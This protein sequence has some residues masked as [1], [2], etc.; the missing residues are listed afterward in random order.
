MTDGANLQRT[1]APQ[2]EQLEIINPDAP[3]PIVQYWNILLRRKWPALAVIGAA[4]VVGLVATLLMAPIYT[5][6]GRIEISRAQKKITNVEGVESEDAGRDIEF[7]QT[8]YNLLKARSLAERV[9]RQLKLSSDAAFFEAHGLDIK[10]G[11]STTTGLPPTSAERAARERE[12]VDMLLKHVN[13]APLRGSSLVDVGYDSG[14]PTQ[15]ARIANAWIKQFI[16]ASIDRRFAST[17]DARAFLERQLSNLREKLEQSER[18]AVNYAS[19]RQIATISR[20]Q[21]PD[22]R[23]QSEKT[24]AAADLETMSAELQRAT[25]DRIA[26]QSRANNMGKGTATAETLSNPAINALRQKRAEVAADYAKILVQFEPEYPAARALK[27]QIDTM[28]ASIS[29]EERRVT[30]N[31]NQ[32]LQAAVQREAE[33]K[34]KVEDLV[35]RLDQQQKSSIQ[36]N[37]YQR[38]ADTNRQLYDSLLQ[39]YKEIGVAGVD[40][41]NISIVDSARVPDRPSAPSLMRNLFLAFLAGLILAALLIVIL[42]QFDEGLRDPED[43]VRK[44]NQPLLGVSP[45]KDT[46]DITA[47]LS[48]PKSDFTEAYISIISNL[49]FSTDHGV[50]RSL[51]IT[52]TR[53]AEGKSS[54]SLALAAVLGRTEK[55]VIL[56]DGD[57]RSPSVHTIVGDSNIS[58][59]SNYLAGDDNWKANVR[60]TSMKGVSIL[61]A[62]PMPPNAAELLSRPRIKD[63]ITELS[64]EYDHIIVDSPPVLGLA[65]GLLIAK[66]V[67]GTVFV[68]EAKG[69]P[70]RGIKASIARLTGVGANIL[71]I[72]LTKVSLGQVGYGYGYG[73]GYGRADELE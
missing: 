48:D 47:D 62:G 58:G 2:G 7:Y 31:R 41:N 46:T 4:L 66:A 16:E 57:M 52:S 65:D 68:S 73:Y 13:V 14:S 22:G 69:A 34:A 54:S 55:R 44:L 12:T 19:T 27:R 3:P 25:T 29:N 71:G 39:R 9:A 33:L 35:A 18:D 17:S 64:H 45:F 67:E 26:A 15:S 21:G 8:Q 42:E 5:A 50:P 36:Y 6:T 24:L 60:A 51:A 70:V 61:T 59:L 30:Q 49:A 23:T 63:L 20:T 32:E 40:A 38:E 11:S 72:V 56:V 53:P 43:V 37:I 1:Y 28:D 10:S